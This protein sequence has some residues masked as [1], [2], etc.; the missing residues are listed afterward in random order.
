[1]IPLTYAEGM[2]FAQIGGGQIQAVSATSLKSYGSVSPWVVRHFPQSRI[3]MDIFTQEPGT[4]RLQ[5]ALISVCL[6]QT[7]IHSQEQ[8][9]N[10]A[11]GNTTI[12][13]AFTGLVPMPHPIT[14]YLVPTTV[15]QKEQIPI[16]PFYIL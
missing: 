4:P 16:P 3:R 1:M 9:L 15:L 13:A 11:P 12:R 5:Q 6:L 14:W 10:T 8:K 2:L 7:R